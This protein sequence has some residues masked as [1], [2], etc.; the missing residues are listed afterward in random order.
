MGCFSCA[1]GSYFRVWSSYKKVKKLNKTYLKTPFCSPAISAMQCYCHSVQHT[2][3]EFGVDSSSCF[4]FRA[5]TH[6]HTD[7]H[8]HSHRHHWSSCT[9]A[10]ADADDNNYTH[11][12]EN[13]RRLGAV[14]YIVDVA[15]S[16]TRRVEKKRNFLACSANL[17]P[18]LYVLF[19]LIFFL[20]LLFFNNHP[21]P[22]Y[23]RIHWT[24]FNDLFTKW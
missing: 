3:T 2:S 19:A 17:P 21:E 4:S 16:R 18:V 11:I 15:V 24:D 14:Q 12:T 7:T 1:F 8:T 22:N 23:I 9:H 5:W 10:S 6:T 20:F 13:L